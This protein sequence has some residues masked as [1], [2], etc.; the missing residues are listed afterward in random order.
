MLD[1]VTLNILGKNIKIEYQLT[2]VKK[3]NIINVAHV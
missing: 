2:E 1:D 3:E